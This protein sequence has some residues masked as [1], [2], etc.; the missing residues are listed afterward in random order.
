MLPQPIPESRKI[1]RSGGTYL[2]ILACECTEVIRVGRLGEM[3]LRPGFYVYLGSSFGPG[4]LRARIGHHLHLSE[5]PHWHVDYLRARTGV[6]GVW[7]RADRVKR[8]HDW[9][10]RIG[11]L[12]GAVIPLRGFG[13]SDCGCPSH[14]Y[15]FPACPSEAAWRRRLGKLIHVRPSSSSRCYTPPDRDEAGRTGAEL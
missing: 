4:G 3:L 1:P 8:E 9:A 11:A 2:L 7:Y 5:R 12:S 13:S 6:Y 15:Y 14:L 10:A